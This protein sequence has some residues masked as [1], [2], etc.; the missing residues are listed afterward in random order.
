MQISVFYCTPHTHTH[1]HTYT[2]LVMDCSHYTEDVLMPA[3]SPANT[4]QPHNT[5][6]TGVVYARGSVNSLQV[7]KQSHEIMMDVTYHSYLDFKCMH[8]FHIYCN[9]GRSYSFIEGCETTQTSNAKDASNPF[10]IY[11]ITLQYD[12]FY[13]FERIPYA[14]KGCI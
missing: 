4:T 7:R 2:H 5:D 10:K 6:I 1:T 11:Y 12:F 13:A 9:Q 14:Q 3:V 8:I